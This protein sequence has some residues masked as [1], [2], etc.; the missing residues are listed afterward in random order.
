MALR[1]RGASTG[2]HRVPGGS[3]LPTGA[4]TDHRAAAREAK[5]RT[6]AARA[7]RR[8]PAVRTT[9]VP[10]A[11]PTAVPTDLTPTEDRP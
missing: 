10:A 4:A 11:V 5:R 2:Q 7:A 9:A 6:R 1:R 8:A 3:A